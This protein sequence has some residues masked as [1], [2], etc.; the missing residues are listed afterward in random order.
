M[1]RRALLASAASLLT[2]RDA[3]AWWPHGAASPSGPNS[4][5]VAANPAQALTTGVNG[6]ARS[7]QIVLGWTGAAPSGVTATWSGGGGAA[8]ISGFAVS[9]SWASFYASNP[10]SAG[11]YNLTVTG[12]GPNTGSASA[13]GIVVSAATADFAAGITGPTTVPLSQ[14]AYGGSFSIGSYACR[15]GAGPVTWSL[16]DTVPGS[17]NAALFNI[18]QGVLYANT[19]ITTGTSFSITVVTTDQIGATQTL[20]VTVPNLTAGTPAIV[21]SA[22]IIPDSSSTTS[23]NYSSYYGGAAIHVSLWNAASATI[24]DPSGLFTWRPGDDLLTIPLASLIPANFGQHNVTITPAGGSAVV[25]PIYI[26]HESPPPLAWV[27]NGGVYSSTPPTNGYGSNQI[28]TL[29]ASADTGFGAFATTSSPSGALSIYSYDPFHGRTGFAYL[30]SSVPA[31]ALSGT[32]QVSSGNGVTNTIVFNLPVSAGVTLP[33]S[34]VSVSTVGGLTNFLPTAMAQTPTGSP[35]TVATISTSGLTPNWSLTTIN[36]VKDNCQVTVGLN[37]GGAMYTPRYAITGSGSSATVTA[38]NLSAINETTP[39]VDTINLTLTDGNGTYCVK[40]FT[41][42][43]SWHPYTGSPV[44]IGPG[45]TFSDFNTFG[46][47]WWAS[48]STYAG[49]VV[50]VLQGCPS[51]STTGYYA[52][53]YTR[54]GWWP[55]PVAF[56]GDSSTQA[57]FTGTISGTTL[58]VSGVTGTINVNDFI[59]TGAGTGVVIVSGSGTT[60]TLHIGPYPLSQTRSIGPVT[61]T[62][63]H[64]QIAFNFAGSA[65][66]GNQGKGGFAFAG[67]YDTIYRRIEAYGVTNGSNAGAFYRENQQSG[68][69]TLEY[70]YPH[71]SD[72]G[73]MNGDFSNRIFLHDNLF[74]TCGNFY[75]S[76]HNIYADGVAYIEVTGNYSVD[77]VGHEFKARA[78][79]AFIDSNFFLEG[80][81]WEGFDTPLQ[82][83]EGG[84]WVVTNNVFMKGTNGGNANNGNIIEMY[85]ECAGANPAHPAWAIN[86]FTC[87]SNTII[88]LAESGQPP[89]GF[90]QVAG[91]TDPIRNIPFGYSI[92]DNDIYNLASGSWSVG[93]YGASAPPLG[94]GNVSITNFPFA[95][96]A[97]VNPLTGGM[98]TNLPFRYDSIS[99]APGTYSMV[100]TLPSASASGTNVTGGLVAGYDGA[101]AQMTAI[102]ASVSSGWT[103]SVSGNNAQ[104]AVNTASLA[105]GLY[106]P[107]ITLTGTGTAPLPAP[108]YFPVVVGT[109]A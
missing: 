92:T 99:S 95:G 9:G 63:Q 39:Q 47:A 33:S 57:T 40:Q 96:I 76:S 4:L 109:G 54:A 84:E 16:I 2:A 10:A 35:T 50:T 68:N 20:A 8:T 94:A 52:I 45:G 59:A 28:G 70:C 53:S 80:M 102:S 75:G 66:I 86:S 64:Q 88:N 6:V 3:F 90:N 27:P 38:W 25:V 101:T 78:M 51:P 73:H 97:L 104:L 49:A 36:V 24:S 62:T 23:P 91:N 19:Q 67:G 81:N 107:L 37:A 42:T 72:M 43:T 29:A 55:G 11:T 5:T 87:G 46:A 14:S 26:A 106:F 58:A 22:N 108:E 105:D 15:G 89:I 93:T 1:F 60:W 77:A 83:C 100:M 71:N 31:G 74:A 12:T 7:S 32:C 65:P 17:G 44:S 61:M 85:N 13:T 69:C 48:P 30:A 79:N 98:P 41:V 56:V 82:N 18:Q 103:I 21:A 34:N